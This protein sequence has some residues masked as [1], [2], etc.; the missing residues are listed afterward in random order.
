MDQRLKRRL[1]WII[2]PP[3][4]FFWLFIAG[5]LSGLG[6]GL[7]PNRPIDQVDSILQDSDEALVYFGFVSCSTVCPVA[8]ANMSAMHRNARHPD[9][10]RLVFISVEPYVPAES[11]RAF[12]QYFDPDFHAIQPDEQQ[13]DNLLTAFKASASTSVRKPGEVDHLDVIY[14]LKRDQGQWL[15]A[16]IYPGNTS[17]NPLNLSP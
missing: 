13:L 8:L 17:V 9:H 10:S 11:S 14:H 2:L 1:G 12:A 5:W 15:M 16:G 4:T 6:N 7:H 3:L